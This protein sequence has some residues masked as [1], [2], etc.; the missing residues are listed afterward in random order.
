MSTRTAEILREI[1]T[2]PAAER[3]ELAENILESL[4]PDD[5]EIERLWAIEAEDRVAAFERNE[6]EAVSAYDVF[7]EID[8]Q[9]TT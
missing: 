5:P 7:R 6:I 2:L 1:L 9:K 3:A 8:Q 4:E